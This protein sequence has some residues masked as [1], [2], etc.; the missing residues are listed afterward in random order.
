MKTIKK[1]IVVLL[2]LAGILMLFGECQTAGQTILIKVIGI[3][4]LVGGLQ[5]AATWRL[6]TEITKD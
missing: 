5:L 2:I 3:G 1:T 6:F 4:S